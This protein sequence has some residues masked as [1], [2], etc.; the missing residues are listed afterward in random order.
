MLITGDR[1]FTYTTN[2]SADKLPAEGWY[3]LECSGRLSE[4][5]VENCECPRCGGADH[6]LLTAAQARSLRDELFDAADRARGK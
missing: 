6:D 2:Y 3:C 5:A 1:T 4:R